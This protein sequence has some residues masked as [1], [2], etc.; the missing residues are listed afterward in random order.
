L[1]ALQPFSPS[2]RQ[3]KFSYLQYGI[4]SHDLT[5]SVGNFAVEKRHVTSEPSFR[6]K[7]A[8]AGQQAPSLAQVSNQVW[9]HIVFKTI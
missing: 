4:K 9:F 6:A 8:A 2:I 1:Q 3:I 7:N 5:I